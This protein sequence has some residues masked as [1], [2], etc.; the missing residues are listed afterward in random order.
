[1]S[2]ETSTKLQFRVLHASPT[3]SVVRA[4]SH[5]EG[6]VEVDK[7]LEAY[8]GPFHMGLSSLQPGSMVA[9]TL[10]WGDRNMSGEV[11]PDLIGAIRDVCVA[12]LAEIQ[13]PVPAL[14]HGPAQTGK[15]KVPGKRGRKATGREELGDERP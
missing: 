4:K 11:H 3:G 8:S 15:S 9:V 13:K 10:Q 6:G 1:M 7:Y 14:P 12:A 2:E 5:F